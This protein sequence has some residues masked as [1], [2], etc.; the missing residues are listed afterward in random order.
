[1]AATPN[2]VA[3]V[4]KVLLID[5]L[6][7]IIYHSLANFVQSYLRELPEPLFPFAK[8]EA[9]LAIV[10]DDPAISKSS[11]KYDMISLLYKQTK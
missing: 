11:D 3:G 1:L 9:A 6:I 4:L 5:L 8:F 7:Y 2:C 10:V